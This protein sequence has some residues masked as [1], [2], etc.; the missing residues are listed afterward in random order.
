MNS[1]SPYV[2]MLSAAW[3]AHLLGEGEAQVLFKI[4]LKLCVV[5]VDVSANLL[6]GFDQFNLQTV[7]SGSGQQ[8]VNV[9]LFNLV[10]L[11]VHLL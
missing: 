11:R 1:A 8:P 10:A 9:A 3:R 2:T 6:Y 5:G 4:P 7:H